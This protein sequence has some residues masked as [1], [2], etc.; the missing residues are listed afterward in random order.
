MEYKDTLL[1]FKTDFE[2]RGNLN[3]KEPVLVEKWKNLCYFWDGFFNVL[4]Y[5]NW[6]I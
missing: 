6:K 1:M 5:L 4:C 2:M 3:Q